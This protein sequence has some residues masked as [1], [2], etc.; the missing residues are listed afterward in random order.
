M[1]GLYECGSVTQMSGYTMHGKL[2]VIIE[3]KAGC[4]LRMGADGSRAI[5]VINIWVCYVPK[6]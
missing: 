1:K 2:F 4:V 6:M 5:A 3:C